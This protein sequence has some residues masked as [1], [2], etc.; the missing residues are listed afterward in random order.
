MGG[1][2]AKLQEVLNVDGY[3]VLR[4]DAAGEQVRLDPG[5]LRLLFEVP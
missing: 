1:L 3:E 5:K 4:F 2:V